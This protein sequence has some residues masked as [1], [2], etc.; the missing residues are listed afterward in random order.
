MPDHRPLLER[1]ARRALT[2]AALLVVGCALLGAAA[3]VEVA[4]VYTRPPAPKGSP[5]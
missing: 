2:V 3:A 5:A 1:G 4:L